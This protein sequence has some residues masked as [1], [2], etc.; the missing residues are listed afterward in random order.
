MHE[1]LNLKTAWP[2]TKVTAVKNNKSGLE[3]SATN[4]IG[5]NLFLNI[6]R[7]GAEVI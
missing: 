6:C 1:A 3:A 2:D 4:R 5:F 7:D